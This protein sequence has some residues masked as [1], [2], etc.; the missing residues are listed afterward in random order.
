[1]ILDI[2]FATGDKVGALSAFSFMD[3]QKRT[4]KCEDTS[5]ITP[6]AYYADELFPQCDSCRKGLSSSDPH[7]F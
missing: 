2:M 7:G 5:A 1:M 3:R 4:A 6:G